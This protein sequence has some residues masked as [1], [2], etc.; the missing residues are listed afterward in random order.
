MDS[1]QVIREVE[2]RCRQRGLRLTPTRR[3]VLELVLS[4]E[5][6]VKA[7][8]LLDQLKAEQPNAAPP[9]I[10][11]ALE[12]LLENHFIHRLESLNA[13]V[14]CFHPA[15][16]HQGQFLICDECQTVTEIH[17]SGLSQHLRDAAEHERFHPS[18][19]VLE[20]YGLCDDCY[21][22]SRS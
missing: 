21:G 22:A 8:D 10:Y 13:F 11:R 20:I 6:P 14:S 1:S 4:A 2:Q 16:S 12:F 9:T 7:Y 15:E 18:R 17:D 19:Q 5:G 3:R